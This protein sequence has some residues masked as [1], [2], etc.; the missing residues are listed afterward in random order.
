MPQF[1][2]DKLFDYLIVIVVVVGPLLAAFTKKLITYFS[3]EKSELSK[4]PE[5]PKK[6]VR[7]KVMVPE[8]KRPVAR[9]APPVARRQ[10]VARPAA[11]RAT[12]AKTVAR[13]ARPS[14][15][16]PITL[17][18]MVDDHL[19]HLTSPVEDEGKRMDKGVEARLG[20]MKTTIR[21][22]TAPAEVSAPRR[23][24]RPDSLVSTSLTE[25]SRQG[26]RQAIVLRE[27]LGPPVALRAPDEEW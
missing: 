21:P 19:G 8:V 27:I 24:Q 12:R 10:P 2:M 16:E 25:L 14:K 7:P 15:D 9:P 26:L 13:R 23:K 18:A 6:P 1:E 3:P 11:P 20:H 17:E 4:P 22:T 5:L